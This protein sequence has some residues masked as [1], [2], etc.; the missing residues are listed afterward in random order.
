TTL[1]DWPCAA[2]V[3]AARTRGVSELPPGVKTSA[4][5][6]DLRMVAHDLWPRRLIERRDEQPVTMP[7]RVFWPESDDDVVAV[8]RA[9]RVARRPLVPFGAGSGV[10]GGISPTTTSWI[11][12]LKRMSRVLSVD[13]ERGVCVVEAGT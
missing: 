7:Q 11:I 5:P 4:D 9:A 12:D 10:C 3:V 6:I 2:G 8:V 13:P 1:S